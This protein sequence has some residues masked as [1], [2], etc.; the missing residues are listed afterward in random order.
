[1]FPVRFL[2]AV[3]VLAGAG[4]APAPA[5]HAAQSY[6]NCTGFID[7]LPTVIHTQGTWC[8]RRN[9][10]TAQSSGPAILIAANHVTIDC[11]D[12]K[13]GNLAAGA[14]S[15]AIG[16][17]LEWG[18]SVTVR[19][20]VVRGFLIGIDIQG[21][22]GHLIE[23]NRIDGSQYVGIHLLEGLPRSIVRGNRVTYIGWGLRD[24]LQIIGI[25]ARGDVVDN[26]V[27]GLYC[28]SGLAV[29]IQHGRGGGEV[30]GNRVRFAPPG[31]A[32]QAVGIRAIGEGTTLSGNRVYS[33]S[34][35][36]GIGIDAHPQDFCSDNT[37]WNFPVAMT[38]RDIGGNAS[39]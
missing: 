11:N 38:C 21:E 36:N 27:E 22:G 5:A 34:P 12:F 15:G 31:T 37:V 14:T 3:G 26:T 23:N 30:S 29:G 35:A 9:L 20:C 25:A 1:M 13:I 10:S 4:L 24:Q 19:N 17:Q 33:E 2:V 8:L 28:P 39:N 7:S 16:I 18:H 32:A 6:D